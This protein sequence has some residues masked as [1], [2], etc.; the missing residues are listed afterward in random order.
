MKNDEKMMQKLAENWSKIDAKIDREQ[1]KP[2]ASY[3]I[4]TNDF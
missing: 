4:K 2:N 3:L 1:K